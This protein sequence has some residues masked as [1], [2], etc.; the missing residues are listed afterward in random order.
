[1]TRLQISRYAQV[2]TNPR[3][4]L[5]LGLHT[6]PQHLIF[7]GLKYKNC[8]LSPFRNLQFLWRSK[9]RLSEKSVYPPNIRTLHL[10]NIFMLNSRKINILTYLNFD[11]ISNFISCGLLKNYFPILS[12]WG[13]GQSPTFN[14]NSNQVPAKLD[15]AKVA[16]TPSCVKY[17]GQ[18]LQLHIMTPFSSVLTLSTNKF[19]VFTQEEWTI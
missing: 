13:K 6:V 19:A 18:F 10:C 3:S 1:M 16:T 2:C 9:H 17:C 14:M 4:Q 5:A 15:E 8:F 12:R 11:I 7:V